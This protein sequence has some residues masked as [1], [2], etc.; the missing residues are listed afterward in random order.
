MGIASDFIG[1]RAEIVCIPSGIFL[2]E[3]VQSAGSLNRMDFWPC[4]ERSQE[5]FSWKPFT[6]WIFFH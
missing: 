1:E 2:F 6:I 5:H 4:L 3:V